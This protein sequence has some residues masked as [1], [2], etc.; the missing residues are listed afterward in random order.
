MVKI[1]HPPQKFKVRQFGMVEATVLNIMCRGH[2]QWHDLLTEFH[3]K[4]LNG[5]KVDRERQSH[6]HTHVVNIYVLFFSIRKVG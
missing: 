4:L 3:T 5:S 2:L 1:F 6:G